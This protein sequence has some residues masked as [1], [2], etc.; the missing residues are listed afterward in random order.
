MVGHGSVVKK[1]VN[2]SRGLPLTTRESN[3]K[4]DM[5]LKDQKFV[6][7]YYNSC[8]VPKLHHAVIFSLDM[9]SEPVWLQFH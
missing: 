2:P 5:L 7:N 9:E 8:F 3:H 6:C 1:K 4:Q